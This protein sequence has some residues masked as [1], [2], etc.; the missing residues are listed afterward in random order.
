MRRIFLTIMLA[1]S[2]YTLDAQ[3][4]TTN[5]N[6]E[7]KSKQIVCS[8]QTHE[9]GQTDWFVK[10][11]ANFSGLQLKDDYKHYNVDRSLGYN[12]EFGF[13][14]R[15]ARSPFFYRL[16]FGACSNLGK[17]RFD[18]DGDIADQLKHL[19]FDDQKH[20]AYLSPLNFGIKIYFGVKI[21]VLVGGFY[22]LE[23]LPDKKMV[24]DY[25]VNA[26]VGLWLSKFYI[27]AL[28]QRG[29]HDRTNDVTQAESFLSNMM[30]RLGF[31]F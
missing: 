13:D 20:A 5:S 24:H 9:G 7:F 6:T 1:F 29:F 22:M 11:G 14:K 17:T 27:G 26:E 30:L 12:L 16:A 2:A 19:K 23:Y 28:V 8:Q 15:I 4:I 25:G 10:L 18:K 31:S 3:I 21:D